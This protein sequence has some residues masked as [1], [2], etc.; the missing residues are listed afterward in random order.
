MT[1]NY[2]KFAVCSLIA[3]GR[4]RSPELFFVLATLDGASHDACRANCSPW[5]EHGHSESERR[6]QP[7]QTASVRLPKNV[8]IT[9]L[10][11]SYSLLR[12]LREVLQA[13]SKVDT[14]PKPCDAR[15]RRRGDHVAVLR[16]AAVVLSTIA[17]SI[18]RPWRT[19][20]A[21]RKVDEVELEVARLGSEVDSW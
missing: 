5:R 21:R 7:K 3:S 17:S 12:Q 1:Q 18:S 16:V 13:E 6:D 14:A 2:G 11:P 4:R 8:C 19:R 10:Q 20:G 9:R 15:N